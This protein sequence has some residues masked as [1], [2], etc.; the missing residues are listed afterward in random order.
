MTSSKD[1]RELL[2]AAGKGDREALDRLVPLVYGELRGLAHRQLAGEHPDHT[3]GATALVNEAYLKLAG[4]RKPGFRDRS[5]FLAI[6]AQAM[7]RIL[8]DHA[9]RR[10]AEKR[11]GGRAPVPLY[12]VEIGGDA[13]I[14]ELVSLDHALARLESLDER[15]A[16]VVECRFFAG[17]T[18]EETAEALGVGT[19]TVKRDWATARAWLNRE[20]SP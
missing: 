16:R 9:V 6:A 11:G 14:E 8:V 5:H 7:R 20:M 4:Y 13:R 15:L 3:L 18:V 17:M 19:A 12:E 10:N 2:A 1:F